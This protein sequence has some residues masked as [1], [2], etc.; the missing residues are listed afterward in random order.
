MFSVVL[1]RDRG[2]QLKMGS[3]TSRNRNLSQKPT[4]H[5]FRDKYKDV[6][7]NKKTSSM[8]GDGENVILFGLVSTRYVY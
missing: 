1:E 3:V 6:F 8:K 2:S 7:R 4:G 5:S